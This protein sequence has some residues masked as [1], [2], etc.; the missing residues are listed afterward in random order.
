MALDAIGPKATPTLW[1]EIVWKQL[2][3]YLD[4]RSV[5]P[6]V[7]PDLLQVEV[8]GTTL[9]MDKI[10]PAKASEDEFNSRKSRGLDAE[11]PSSAR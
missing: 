11:L 4:S 10:P 2:L 6:I 5:I 3:A 8:D 1:S 9:L 7:G